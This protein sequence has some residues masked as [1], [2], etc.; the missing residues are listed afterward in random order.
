[1]TKPAAIFRASYSDWKLIRTRKCVQIILEV[2]LEGGLAHAAYAALGGMPDPAA[3]TW[4]A[5][6][7]LKTTGKMVM[8]AIEPE[9]AKEVMPDTPVHTGPTDDTQ[10]REEVMSNPQLSITSDTSPASGPDIPARAH[11]P[12]AAE[13]RLAQRAGILCAD[14][15][16]QKYLRSDN[17]EEAAACVRLYCKVNSRSEIKPGTEAGRLFVQLDNH[18]IAWRDADKYVEASA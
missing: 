16:F 13:K 11:K 7:R 1:M 5:V 17:E 18:F 12:V 8:D 15:L 4:V 2:P 14:P 10:S 9:T 6:A 3:E